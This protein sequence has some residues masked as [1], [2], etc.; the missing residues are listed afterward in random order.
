MRMWDNKV[1]CFNPLIWGIICHTGI[2][3]EI[4]M[5]GRKEI[6]RKYEGRANTRKETTPPNGVGMHIKMRFYFSPD[7]LKWNS[8]TV[9]DI[10]N[11]KHQIS[12]SKL[13]AVSES[14]LTLCNKAEDTHTTR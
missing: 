5:V 10:E 2:D 8:L 14:G 13:I 4:M 3:D 6:I 1:D 7:Q 12:E 11:Y 9:T